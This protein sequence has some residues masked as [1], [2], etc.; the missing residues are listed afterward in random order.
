M[1][2][3]G[4]SSG[5]WRGRPVCACQPAFQQEGKET[6]FL[7]VGLQEWEHGELLLLLVRQVLASRCKEKKKLFGETLVVSQGGLGGPRPGERGFNSPSEAVPGTGRRKQGPS[8]SFIGQQGPC[9]SGAVDIGKRDPK[10]EGKD[11]VF[12]DIRGRCG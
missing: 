3:A 9:V 4:F 12:L 1:V 7:D 6:F 10:Q 8:P 5:L 11:L 2:G